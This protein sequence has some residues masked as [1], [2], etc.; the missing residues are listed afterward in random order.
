[1][2]RE[3]L[4]GFRARLVRATESQLLVRNAR[5]V[6]ATWE[7]EHGEITEEELAAVERAWRA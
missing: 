1:M 7:H 2:R 6:I 3:L 4:R 5:R